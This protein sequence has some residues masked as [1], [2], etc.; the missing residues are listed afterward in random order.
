MDQDRARL[1]ELIK[2]KKAFRRE[3]VILASGKA[4]DFYFDGK[5]IT[6]D[7]EGLCLMAKLILRQ[8]TPGE[9]T[10]IGGPTLGA[11]PI[12]AAVSVLSFQLGWQPP[13]KAFIV[14]KQP[15]GHGLKKAIE[16][17]LTAGESVVV[18]ED[19][20]TTGGSIKEAIDRIEEA[21]ARVAKIICLLDRE[22]GAV[23][24]LSGYQIISLVSKKEIW[25]N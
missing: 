5:Q 1:L 9:A 24:A 2:A 10:S 19:V 20:I 16:G 7:P 6:L 13:L 8:L 17:Q 23:A 15:K 4:S 11:D 18:V 21:G 22:E 25:Q 3:A 12:A 14:R